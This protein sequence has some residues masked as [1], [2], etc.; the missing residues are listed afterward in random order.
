MK[1]D[2][3]GLLCGEEG[4]SDRHPRHVTVWDGLRGFDAVGTA[5]SAG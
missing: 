2:D 3:S 4:S 1:H 5:G